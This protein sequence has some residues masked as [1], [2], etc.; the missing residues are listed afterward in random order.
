MTREA[1]MIPMKQKKVSG[2]KLQMISVA[3]RI[4]D[5]KQNDKNNK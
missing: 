3:W 4:N 2:E 1:Q 5:A